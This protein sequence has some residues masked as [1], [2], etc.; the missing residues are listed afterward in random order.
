MLFLVMVSTVENRHEVPVAVR[1]V[2]AADG[3]CDTKAWTTVQDDANKQ[4]TSK[5]A[6][7]VMGELLVDLRLLLF[8][9]NIKI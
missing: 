5:K 4:A 9:N 6:F 8:F 2:K 7:I 1:R 3:G